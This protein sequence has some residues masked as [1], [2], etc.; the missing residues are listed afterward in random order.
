MQLEAELKARRKLT[1]IIFSVAALSLLAWG[2]FQLHLYFWVSLDV[3]RVEVHLAVCETVTPDLVAQGGEIDA[4]FILVGAP[5]ED[6]A[7]IVDGELSEFKKLHREPIIISINNGSIYIAN[8]LVD[9]D[10]LIYVA[11]FCEV[12]YLQYG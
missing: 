4:D 3:T 1:V 5:N 10:K 11:R 2:L 7:P 6:V 12:I 9:K 8:V